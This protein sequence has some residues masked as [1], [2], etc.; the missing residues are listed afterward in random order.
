[1]CIFKI[2]NDLIVLL[3]PPLYGL[4]GN[5]QERCCPG[6]QN[7]F[8]AWNN[9]RAGKSVYDM[10]TLGDKLDS[11]YHTFHLLL[12]EPTPPVPSPNSVVQL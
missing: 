6:S 11:K 2:A 7:K 4:F 12:S 8:C 5:I 9:H 1:M 10:T 3:A